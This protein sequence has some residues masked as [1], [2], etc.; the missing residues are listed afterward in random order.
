MQCT[1]LLAIGLDIVPALRVT[2]GFTRVLI[3]YQ[4]LIITVKQLNA[5]A[6]NEYNTATEVVNNID[7]GPF[8][9]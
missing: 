2:T 1:P 4:N 6:A 8:F 3:N 7:A 5:N 9:H